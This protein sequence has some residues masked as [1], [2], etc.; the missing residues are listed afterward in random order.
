MFVNNYNSN[1]SVDQSKIKIF[2][3]IILIILKLKSQIDSSKPT[4]MLNN[5]TTKSPRVLEK[6]LFIPLNCSLN[7]KN[8]SIEFAIKLNNKQQQLH[9][10][11][12]KLT[13]QQQ[14]S[15]LTVFPSSLS[16]ATTYDCNMDSF[17][18]NMTRKGLVLNVETNNLRNSITLLNCANNNNNNNNKTTNNGLLCDIKNGNKHVNILD[19]VHSNDQ[20]HINQHISN[21]KYLFILCFFVVYNQKIVFIFIYIFSKIIKIFRFIFT[22]HIYL[23]LLI[24]FCIFYCSNTYTH[25]HN[26]KNIFRTIFVVFVVANCNKE[27]EE[28]MK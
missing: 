19:Y 23:L 10:N 28:E 1:Q 5:T 24:F 22:I 11:N 7:E 9:P 17:K 25:T 6:M 15:N 27:E 8:Q 12:L 14:S 3:Y 16:N 26:K 2:C 20:N 13:R 18:T 4:N 21:G